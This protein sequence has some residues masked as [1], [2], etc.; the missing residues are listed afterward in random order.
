MVLSYSFLFKKVFNQFQ[1]MT[2]TIF[3]M[4]AHYTTLNT[5]EKGI[6]VFTYDLANVVKFLDM[7]QKALGF[8]TIASNNLI[9]R[10]YCSVDLGN[11]LITA[12][13][14]TGTEDPNPL[15]KRWYVWN[16]E[17]KILARPSVWNYELPIDPKNGGCTYVGAEYINT[18]D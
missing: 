11:G 8:Q 18:C 1:F 4:Q 10:G 5:G 9:Y 16:N 2:A 12:V 14:G 3:S 7:D 17:T 13:G 6:L 15:R